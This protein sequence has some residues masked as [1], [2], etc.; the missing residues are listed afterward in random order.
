VGLC[1][2][3]VSEIASWQPRDLSYKDYAVTPDRPSLICIKFV[4]TFLSELTFAGC[5]S[6]HLVETQ[7]VLTVRSLDGTAKSV[8]MKI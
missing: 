4:M 1:L 5:R 3:R 2:F 6:V 8:R 7:V